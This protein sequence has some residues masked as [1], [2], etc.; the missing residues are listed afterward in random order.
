[1]AW[2]KLVDLE[3]DDE[4]QLDAICPMPMADRPRYPFGTRICLTHKEL[5]KLGLEADCDVGDLIDLRCFA[6]VTSISKNDSGNGED[7]RIE[8]QI[9]HMA[10]E[11]E[12]SE[13][14]EEGD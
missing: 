8:L 6:E 2:S 1:M 5:A 9:T 14:T 3:L 4:D 11:D 12:M 10:A 7:C 13:G